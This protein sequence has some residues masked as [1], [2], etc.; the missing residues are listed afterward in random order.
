MEKTVHV[1]ITSK[2]TEAA[3]GRRAGQG[4]PGRERDLVCTGSIKS[5]F[6]QTTTL[7]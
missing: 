7:R 4:P 3:V 2:G 6:S 5:K 1:S